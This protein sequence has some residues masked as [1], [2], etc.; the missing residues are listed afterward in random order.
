MRNRCDLFAFARQ[1]LQQLRKVQVV[2][3]MEEVEV[4]LRLVV[5]VVHCVA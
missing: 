2:D 3:K 4:D 1:H 5:V